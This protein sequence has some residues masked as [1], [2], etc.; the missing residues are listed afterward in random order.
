MSGEILGRRPVFD[1]WSK[2]FLA[3]VRLPDG[4]V[5]E[6]EIEDHGCGVG[7]LPYDPERRT[8]L[9]VR[10]PR[11]PVVH[12]GEPDLLE[13]PAGMIE[14]ERAEDAGRREVLEE[15]GAR[16]SELEFVT[17]AWPMA[18]VS[19]ERIYL[20]LAPYSASDRVEEGGGAEGEHENITVVETPLA[21][22]WRRAQDRSLR[23]LKTLFLLYV[24]KERRPELFA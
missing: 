3:R 19:T 14:G 23:D 20:Y 1:G 21:E 12:V 24:L 17:A 2:L 4:E 8:A 16:L 13:V 11:A 18:S 5:V 9:L 15:V 6:R 22:L 7:V 10:L